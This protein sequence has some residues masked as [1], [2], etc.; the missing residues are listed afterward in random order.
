MQ[1]SIPYW[2]PSPR[3]VHPDS[4][5]NRR[6][7]TICSSTSVYVPSEHTAPMALIHYLPG[8]DRKSPTL[9]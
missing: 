4:K 2:S 3:R 7:M 5:R 1:W 8:T 6:G 9:H